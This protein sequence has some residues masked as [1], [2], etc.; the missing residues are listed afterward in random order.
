MQFKDLR[1]TP[2]EKLWLKAIYENDGIPDVK[3]FKVRLHGQL[4]ADF[5]HE[6]LQRCFVFD[7]RLNLY[8]IWAINPKDRVFGR[9]DKLI[10][11]I[12][13]RIQ[14]NPRLETLTAKELSEETGIPV[15]ETEEALGHL[16][17]LHGFQAGARSKGGSF[18][19]EEIKL[20]GDEYIG[21]Y[22]GYK[23]I[24]NLLDISWNA[25]WIPA[26]FHPKPAKTS[27]DGKTKLRYTKQCHTVSYG[28]E[29]WTFHSNAARVV[30]VLFLA[31]QKGI[32]ETHI[33]EIRAEL[34]KESQSDSLS[35]VFK[36]RDKDAA[37]KNLI[38]QGPSGKGFY[39]LNS[40]YLENGIEEIDLSDIQEENAE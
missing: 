2:P 10:K 33:N 36:K 17:K 25:S 15:T 12:R 6:T 1:L 23:D 28:R 19:V 34:P 32:R 3:T 40:K 39:Q 13:G 16:I 30:R 37:W 35:Q 18:G 20:G 29:E 27:E 38:I 14:K 21:R 9:V 24:S 11:A 4:P 5:N 31:H 7:N 26:V 22:L 8:G